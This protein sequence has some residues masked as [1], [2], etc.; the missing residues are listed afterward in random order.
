MTT[1]G[2]LEIP[3]VATS[4][5]SPGSSTTPPPGSLSRAPMLRGSIP[6]DVSRGGVPAFSA[7][8][9]W[10]TPPVGTRSWMSGVSCSWMSSGSHSSASAEAWFVVLGVWNTAVSGR[11]R[12]RGGS[13]QAVVGPPGRRCFGPPP[14][15]KFVGPPPGCSDASRAAGS[16]RRGLEPARRG[17]I[18]GDGSNASSGGV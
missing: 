16:T 3:G 9:R 6:P 17:L 2:Y 11:L 14:D 8:V 4:S 5:N 1:P 10:E 12:V 13:A 18:T 7:G 15:G